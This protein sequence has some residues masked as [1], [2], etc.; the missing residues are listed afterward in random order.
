MI[1]SGR[2]VTLGAWLEELP[3]GSVE[4]RPGLL[5][6]QAGVAMMRGD[7]ILGLSLASQAI[8]GLTASHDLP[9]LALNLIRRSTANRMLGNYQQALMDAEKALGLVDHQ[10]EMAF[11]QADALRVKG[12][13]LYKQGKLRD[14]LGCLSQSV[15]IYQ[16]IKD[17]ESAFSSLS[18][19]KQVLPFRPATLQA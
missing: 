13:C 9:A 10:P 4:N 5:S 7:P 11:Y 12:T 1:S 8:P 16:S 3:I 6:I 15:M 14:A 17:E 2:L 18:K 19:T